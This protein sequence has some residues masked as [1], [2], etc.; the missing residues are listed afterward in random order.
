MKGLI[1]IEIK[2]SFNKKDNLKNSENVFDNISSLNN[3]NK[4]SPETSSSNNVGS[5]TNNQIGGSVN[6]FKNQNKNGFLRGIIIGAIGTVLGAL[7]T[8]FIFGIK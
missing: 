1:N 7:I 5:I 6:V 2:N 8:Y 3:N 4:N